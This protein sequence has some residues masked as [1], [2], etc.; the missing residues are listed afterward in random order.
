VP[1]PRLTSELFLIPLDGRYLV[2]APL[3]QAAFVGNAAL[4]RLVGDLN[5]GRV[6]VADPT[7]ASLVGFLRRLEM[8]DAGHETRPLI[9]A[10]GPVRPTTVTLFVTTACN[11]RC[12]YCYAR[13]GERPAHAMSAEV[14]RHGI[15]FVVANALEL[16][17]REVEVA[18]HGGGEP[19]TNWDTLVRSHEY[20]RRRAEACGLTLRTMMATNG[21]LSEAQVDWVTRHITEA[22]LS[23]DGLPQAQ[24]ANRPTTDGHGSSGPVLATLRR[25]DEARFAYSLR[26]TVTHETIPLLPAAVDYI[27]R[28][29]R[30]ATIHVEPAYPMGR[31]EAWPSAETAAFV[32]AFRLAQREAWAHH[33]ELRFSPVRVGYLS[34]HFCGVTQDNFCLLADD[35]V[36]SCF[37]AFSTDQEPAHR[38]IYGAYDPAT[39]GYGFDPARTEQLRRQTVDRLESCR[40]CFARWT[41][42][43]DCLYRRWATMGEPDGEGAPSRCRLTRELT[44]DQVLRRVALSGGLSWHERRTDP[45]VRSGSHALAGLPQ[46]RPALPRVSD[47]AQ[48]VPCVHPVGNPAHPAPSR[49]GVPITEMR[50]RMEGRSR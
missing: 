33:Q 31:G 48:P 25:L 35:R 20:A 28:S 50:A 27:C 19:T 38:F 42:A 34:N 4:A 29:F 17:R 43:G 15:D 12:V 21:V 18:Y 6:G 11:L 9:R 7:V 13:A 8:A 40:R 24:D 3:R 2:Y 22:C 49:E 41:C 39:R 44:R 1:E 45:A 47:A 10:R 46:P 23:F 32:E 30:P 37:E 16:G 14:A 36:S 5:E 26:L